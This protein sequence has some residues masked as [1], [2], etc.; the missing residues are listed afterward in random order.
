MDSPK[1]RRLGGGSNGGS[2]VSADSGTSEGVVSCTCAGD[3][4]RDAPSKTGGCDCVAENR[5][6]RGERGGERTGSDEMG[7]GGTKGNDSRIESARVEV[8]ETTEQ[9]EIRLRSKPWARACACACAK[10]NC[11][12]SSRD[13]GWREVCA[14]AG[15]TSL[16]MVVLGDLSG[17][18]GHSS[19]TLT[20]VALLISMI[21][22]A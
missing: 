20:R 12:C 15:V 1:V 18:F 3:G 22:P 5:W 17:F 19:P 14:E 4:E 21:D 6:C 9:P 8:A 16:P 13:A 11:C 7:E 2:W 10:A